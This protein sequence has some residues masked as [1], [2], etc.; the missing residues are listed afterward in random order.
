GDPALAE[1][2]EQRLREVEPGCRRR[3]RPFDPGVHRLVALAVLLVRRTPDVRRQ[4]DLSLLPQRA[5]EIAVRDPDDA[6]RRTRDV[7]AQRAPPLPPQ[8]AV[9]IALRDLD[10]ALAVG[11][12]FD[13]GEP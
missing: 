9:E 7:R 10:D 13:Y 12:L 5:G 11:M 3:D 2:S 1:R 4:R 8:R 6:V